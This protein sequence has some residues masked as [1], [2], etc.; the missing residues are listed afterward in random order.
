MTAAL[1]DLMAG[2]PPNAIF[3]SIRE[4]ARWWSHNAAPMELFEVTLAALDQLR[5]KPLHK[6][7]RKRLLWE[8]WQSLDV[9]S[10]AAFLAKIGGAE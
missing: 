1:I 9:D 2:M 7:M 6:D 5:S 3:G 4:E 8:M 10:R